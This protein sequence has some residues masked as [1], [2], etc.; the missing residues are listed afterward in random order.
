MNPSRL[1]MSLVVALDIL[2]CCPKPSPAQ[3]YCALR[4]PVAAVFGLFP[5]ASRYGSIVRDVGDDARQTISAQLGLQLHHSE[6]G[7]HTLYAVYDDELPI[8]LVHVR[9][10]RTRWGLVEIIWGLDLDLRVRDFRFQRCRSPSQA[11]IGAEAFRSALVGATI[12]DLSA[13]L[14]DDKLALNTDHLPLPT[15]HHS[16]AFAVI[17]SALKTIVA[18]ESVWG[19]DLERL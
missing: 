1:R 3:T 7:K 14:S 10:E 8:G 19:A 17:S 2:L 18:T 5:D 16:L 12:D 13:M 11:F 6:L 9:A 15:E 4:D